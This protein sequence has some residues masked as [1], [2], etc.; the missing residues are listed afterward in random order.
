[1]TPSRRHGCAQLFRRHQAVTLAGVAG[2]GEANA[3]WDADH[4]CDCQTKAPRPGAHQGVGP[5]G[6][7][8]FFATWSTLT[9]AD[10]G[11]RFFL[12]IPRGAL[13]RV[14]RSSTRRSVDDVRCDRDFTLTS[15]PGRGKM[16]RERAGGPS[17]GG[18]PKEGT[19]LMGSDPD[20]CLR[21]IAANGSFL[22]SPQAL[23]AP[24]STRHL[25]VC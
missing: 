15:I 13:S 4:C 8:I 21:D 9:E 12:E 19:R 18:S 3:P 16:G 5:L 24:W 14:T 2:W 25:Y 20:R 1:M 7:V 23:P 17:Q 10:R 11:T 22:R 6:L